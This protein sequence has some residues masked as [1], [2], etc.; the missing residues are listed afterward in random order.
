MSR[1]EDV[2]EGCNTEPPV[3]FFTLF[4]VLLLYSPLKGIFLKM[5]TI[6]EKK[7]SLEDLSKV[8][9]ERPANA[10]RSGFEFQQS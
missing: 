9:L 4:V 6:R 8:K 5:I 10:W 2:V 7:A 3:I 1:R